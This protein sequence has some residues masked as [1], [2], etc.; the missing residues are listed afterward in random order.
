MI[1]GVVSAALEAM[2]HL[3]VQGPGGREQ[4]I[5]AIIDTGFNGALTLPPSLIATLGLPWLARERVLLGDG[6]VEQLDVYAATV[7]WD[8]QPLRVTADAADT[9]PLV[10]MAL[11]YGYELNIRNVEG[12]AVTLERLAN[13]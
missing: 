8:R 13:P 11:M 5:K 10:G 1:T 4:E 7:V 6:R 12:G 2:I 9:D 3:S